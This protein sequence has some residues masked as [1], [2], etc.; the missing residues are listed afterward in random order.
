[1]GTHDE[2]I[3]LKSNYYELWQMQNSEEELKEM[4]K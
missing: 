3:A 2:L 4:K 1:M